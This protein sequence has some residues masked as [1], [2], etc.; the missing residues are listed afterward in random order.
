MMVL[1]CLYSPCVGPLLISRAY[2][3]YPFFSLYTSRAYK[4]SK[5]GLGGKADRNTEV[6]LYQSDSEAKPPPIGSGTKTW[7]RPDGKK[8]IEVTHASA[9][10]RLW[11]YRVGFR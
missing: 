4:K 8:K 2:R 3:K 5:E 9:R 10:L 7:V 11:N 1:R 6:F